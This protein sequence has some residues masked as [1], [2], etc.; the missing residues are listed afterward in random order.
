MANLVR[1]DSLAALRQVR[2]TVI[3]DCPKL[4]R[5]GLLP[6]LPHPAP[7]R[8][9]FAIAMP[10]QSHEAV[11]LSGERALGRKQCRFTA[12]RPSWRSQARW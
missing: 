1:P 3:S 11:F 10:E 5:H 2:R 4:S 12:L 6:G 8:T 9:G 7:S